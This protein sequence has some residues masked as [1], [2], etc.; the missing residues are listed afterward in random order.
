MQSLCYDII[1]KICTHLSFE[2]VINFHNA[3]C[4]FICPKLVKNN[5]TKIIIQY[6]EYVARLTSEIGRSRRHG[7]RIKPSK[8]KDT[9]RSR[10]DRPD[11]RWERQRRDC[12]S[13]RSLDTRRKRSPRQYEG[14]PDERWEKQRI[15]SPHTQS[16]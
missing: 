5:L 9:R 10:R 12:F 16:Q 13:L 11:E 1:R 3:L 8:P 6:D 14:N 4:L 15:D 7:K 2:E